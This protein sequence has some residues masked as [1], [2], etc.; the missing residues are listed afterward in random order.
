VTILEA[1]GLTRRYGRLTAVSAVDLT[2]T[3]GRVLALLGPN[4]AG[5][6]ST[7]DLICGSAVPDEG[8]VR[9]NGELAAPPTLRRVVGL[10][11]QALEFWPKLTC[12]E[13]L[14]M[15]GRL[16]GHTQAAAMERAS[17]LLERLGLTS[18]SSARAE[19]LSGGMKRR[20]NLALAMV[21]DPP[22]L[23]FDEPE[24]GLDPQSRAMVRELIA[25]LAQDH[26]VLLTSHDIAEVERVADEVIV[27]DHGTVLARGT[28]SELVAR[29]DLGDEVDLVGEPDA[30]SRALAGTALLEPIEARAD[31][32]RLRLR[33]TGVTLGSILAGLDRHGV[34]VTSVRSRP[35]NLEDVFLTLTG[36]SLR[37]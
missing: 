20:L 8:T 21:N 10:C 5:K 18:K 35:A 4:G 12:A 32:V 27:I 9:F 33:R 36:R 6:T 37:G 17:S 2:I 15:I 29:H 24:A 30:L 26:A 11:P 31:G 3:S 22:V 14:V 1:S 19:T 7:I 34:E 16:F 28:P 23:V 13:Q 25:E